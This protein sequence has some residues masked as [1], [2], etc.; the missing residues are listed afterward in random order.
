MHHS[1]Q[2]CCVGC[3]LVPPETETNYTLVERRGWRLTVASGDDGRKTPELR[4]PSCWAAHRERLGKVA[5]PAGA[6]KTGRHL[7]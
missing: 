6:S 4:C 2:R 7:P 5:H 1:E 3:G